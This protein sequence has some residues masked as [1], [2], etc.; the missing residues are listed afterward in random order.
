MEV[1]ETESRLENDIG[2]EEF[3]ARHE[4]LFHHVD[5]WYKRKSDYWKQ[6]FREQFM[7]DMDKNLR[8]FHIVAIMRK[9][10][11]LI[12]EVSGRVFRESRRIK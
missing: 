8:Y 1:A 6:L 9:R 12:L 5:L 2:N 4:A 7:K 3:L 11:K 10:K